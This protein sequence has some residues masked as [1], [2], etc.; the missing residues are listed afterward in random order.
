MLQHV[1]E[2][3]GRNPAK[4]QLVIEEGPHHDPVVYEGDI[5]GGQLL[6]R[7][8][9]G[10]MARLLGFFHVSWFLSCFLSECPSG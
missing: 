3:F 2:V 4:N 1:P 6:P 5:S 10:H 7:F 8:R 9:S